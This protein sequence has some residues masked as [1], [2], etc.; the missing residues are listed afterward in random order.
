M[1]VLVCAAVRPSKKLGFQSMERL[2]MPPWGPWLS[3]IQGS[4]FLSSDGAKCAVD[5]FR[6][7]LL[8]A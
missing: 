2:T 5:S 8:K 3:P 6:G 7:I 1:I 4:L